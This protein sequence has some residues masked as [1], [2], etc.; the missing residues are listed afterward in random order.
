MGDQDGSKLIGTWRLLA[1]YVVNEE[2]GERT[3]P[4]GSKP[5]GSIIVTPG[6]RLMAMLMSSDRL[7]AGS[8]PDGA[9]LFK[10][11]LAYTGKYTA[12]GEKFTTAVDMAW[13]PS[14]D[15][16]DQTRYYTLTGE[17]L[18]IRTAPHDHPSF[19]GQKIVGYL[20]WERES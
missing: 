5:R 19:P 14:W 7:P 6:G 9:T 12:D 15:G 18:Q 16:T 2:T 20:D 10:S 8:Q 3:E 4:F 1:V 11:M 17:Q 13:D